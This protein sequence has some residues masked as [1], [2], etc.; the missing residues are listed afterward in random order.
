MKLTVDGFNILNAAPVL[1]YSSN[2]LSLLGTS[3]NPVLPTERINTIL[4][5]RV[6][7]AGMTFWF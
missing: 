3:S 7:R 1:G 4:P 2:N 5:P 6:F